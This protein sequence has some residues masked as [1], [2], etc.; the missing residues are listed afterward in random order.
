MAQQVE[1]L[2]WPQHAFRTGMILPERGETWFSGAEF[3]VWSQSVVL[4]STTFNVT[5]GLALGI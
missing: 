4:Q 1:D 5:G 3:Y 2:G